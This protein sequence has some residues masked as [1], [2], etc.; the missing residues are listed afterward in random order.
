MR[1]LCKF[2]AVSLDRLD[3]R[4]SISKFTVSFE[5]AIAQR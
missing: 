1:T 2:A 4:E 5:S 3:A